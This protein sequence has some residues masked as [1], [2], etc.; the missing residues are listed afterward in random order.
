MILKIKNESKNELPRYARIGDSGFDL[1]ANV[2][3]SVVILPGRRAI[4]PTGLHVDIPEGYELQ[5]RSRS[6]LAAKYGIQAH[7]GTIDCG[8]TDEICIILFNF[9]EEN[10]EVNPGDRIAQAVFAKAE[11]AEIVETKET[12][13]K[14]N[15]R[16]GG[17]GSTGIN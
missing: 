14:E 1:R 9:G 6:G 17:F 4:I 11:Q 15:D 10:F 2:G 3:R 5:I 13:V 7:P 12:I 16:G 8:Y